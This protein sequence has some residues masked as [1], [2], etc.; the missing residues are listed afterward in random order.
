MNYNEVNF[1]IVGGGTAGWITALLLRK[2][3][4]H[5]NITV[6]ESSEIGILGA[7]E[8]TTP[9]FVGFLEQVDVNLNDFIK[10]TKATIKSGIKFTNWNGDGSYYLHPFSEGKFFNPLDS[11]LPFISH[12]SE[13]KNLNEICCS[14]LCNEENKVKFYL[15]EGKFSYLGSYALHFDAR[16]TADYLKSIAIERNITLIDSNVINFETDKNNFI[17]FVVLENF[18]KISCDFIFDCTGL[19]RQ[20]IG[21]F[22]NDEWL[23][24]K[25]SLPCDKAQP[26][27]IKNN[28]KSIPPYTEAIAMK[29]GW[30]WKIPVQGRYGCGY[31]YDSS[32]VNE[33]NIKKE[34]LENFPEA[35]IPSKS[36]SFKAG[37]F[38]NPWTKNCVS[39]GLSSGFIEPLEATSIW[40]SL[41]S[42][43]YLLEEC[44]TGI[45]SYN[46][47]HNNAYNN[48]VLN[49]NNEIKDFL[50]VHYLTK[51]NDSLFWKEFKTK[52]KLSSSIQKFYDFKGYIELIEHQKEVFL[53]FQ[54]YY[55]LAG[56]NFY[57]VD[58]FKEFFDQCL[59]HPKNLN[60]IREI[61]STKKH[62][63][64]FADFKAVDHYKF[65]QHI[66]NL[67]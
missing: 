40:V 33:D 65:L 53:N 19:H 20:I 32:Y 64:Q 54:S 8:G 11:F 61:E 37:Y 66:N 17:K 49:L 29:Y 15:D 45:L 2:K 59:K 1:V 28:T 4:P 3:F 18:Q 42:L 31:V 27:F 43:Q 48:Y 35:E 23:D 24:Y 47:S 5:N 26:F 46:E 36:F 67:N 6:V 7:G 52:N 13:G 63:K 51:R 10:N 41:L 25:E 21:K 58:V 56:V 57:N 14:D 34:I 60:L 30:V 16:L 22:Y 44:F 39:I 50:Q 38:K 12:V 55:V 62:M 9:Y